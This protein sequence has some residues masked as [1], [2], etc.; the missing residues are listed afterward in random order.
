[1]RLA[2]IEFNDLPA[3]ELATYRSRVAAVTPALAS[4]D[5][6]RAHAGAGHASRSSVV[7]KA[8]EIRAPLEEAFGPVTVSVAFRLRRLDA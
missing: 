1:M 2:E 4:R 7:G 3:D 8:S 6:A 5:G